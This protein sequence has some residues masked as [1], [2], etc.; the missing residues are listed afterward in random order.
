[1]E[2]DR[3]DFGVALEEGDCEEDDEDSD[4][5]CLEI[6][7]DCVEDNRDSLEVEDEDS[8]EIFNGDILKDSPEISAGVSI[9]DVA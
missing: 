3:E 9:E 7:D 1:L 2:E 6:E 5:L 8:P 4:M